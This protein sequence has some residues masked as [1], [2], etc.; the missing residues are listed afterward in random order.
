MIEAF[1]LYRKAFKTGDA[2]Y[3]NDDV[4]LLVYNERNECFVAFDGKNEEEFLDRLERSKVCG[5]NLFFE[6]CRQLE[7]STLPEGIVPD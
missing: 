7:R 3:G 6:E 1:V 2:L 5:R 4:S